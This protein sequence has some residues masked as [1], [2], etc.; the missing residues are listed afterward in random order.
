MSK[1]AR[2]LPD[3]S[4]LQAQLAALAA[5]NERLKAQTSRETR[6]T[7]EDYKGTPVLKFEGNFKPF[8]AGMSKLKAILEMEKTVQ[9]FIK[10]SGKSID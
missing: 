3:I 2:I 4:T 8:H 9:K 5:E 1:T 10:T 6:V 7:L